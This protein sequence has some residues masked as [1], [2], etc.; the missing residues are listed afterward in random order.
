MLKINSFGQDAFYGGH[1]P[2]LVEAMY[3][4]D[5]VMFFYIHRV[6]DFAPNNRGLNI[7][8]RNF[9]NKCNGEPSIRLLYSAIYTVYY[10]LKDKELYEAIANMIEVNRKMLKVIH[11]CLPT[12]NSKYFKSHQPEYFARLIIEEYIEVNN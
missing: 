12:L 5:R 10:M 8:L 7:T 11:Q 6:M 4:V 3:E 1:S 9:C 2:E